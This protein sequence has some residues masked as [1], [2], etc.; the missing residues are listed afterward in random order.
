[1]TPLRRL[2]FVASLL[3]GCIAESED[4]C[5]FDGRYEMGVIS[6]TGCESTT[7]SISFFDEEGE[8][9]TLI[10]QIADDGAL[11]RGIITCE[12]GDPVVECGGF[13]TASNDCRWD[14]YI[15]RIAR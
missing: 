15:R 6:T 5:I 4:A 2:F 7:E 9:E 14:I 12:P 10:S 3:F 11:Q 1:M 8:C 13:M